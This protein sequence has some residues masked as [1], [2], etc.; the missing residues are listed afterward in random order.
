MLEGGSDSSQVQGAYVAV[1]FVIPFW[2]S[3]PEKRIIADI[4]YGNMYVFK[5]GIGFRQPTIECNKQ[6]NAFFCTID[7]TV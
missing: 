7:F 5:N 1:A 4:L 2:S 3:S 6:A